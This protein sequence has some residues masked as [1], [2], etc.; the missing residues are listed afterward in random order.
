M[1]IR[2]RDSF[3]IDFEMLDAL[4]PGWYVLGAGLIVV[5][6]DLVRV[7]FAKPRRSTARPEP[8]AA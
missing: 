6:V 3:D 7:R 5:L 4:R 1:C 2:D 8:A